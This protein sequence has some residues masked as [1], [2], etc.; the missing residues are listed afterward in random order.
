MR[1][2]QRE[3]VYNLWYIIC[4]SYGGN[5]GENENFG[6]WRH[7]ELGLG[8]YENDQ[9]LTMCLLW[10]G[11]TGTTSSN[12]SEYCLTRDSTGQLKSTFLPSPTKWFHGGYHLATHVCTC[13]DSKDLRCLGL[14]LSS[15]SPWTN[16]LHHDRIKQGI[17]HEIIIQVKGIFEPYHKVWLCPNMGRKTPQPFLIGHFW[18]LTW[19]WTTFHRA[20][21]KPQ[22]PPREPQ[23]ALAPRPHRGKPNLHPSCRTGIIMGRPFGP[24]A[25][26]QWLV[27]GTARGSRIR[28]LLVQFDECKNFGENCQEIHLHQLP[29]TYQLQRTSHLQ[30]TTKT[31]KNGIMLDGRFLPM[32]IWGNTKNYQSYLRTYL[33]TLGSSFLSVNGFW[34]Q[35]P[36][37]DLSYI[38]TFAYRTLDLDRISLMCKSQ[39]SRWKSRSV[40]TCASVMV[41]RSISQIKPGTSHWCWN[42]KLASMLKSPFQSCHITFFIGQITFLCWKITVCLLALITIMFVP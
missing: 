37:Q 14:P 42:L 9:I 22:G 28:V 25:K 3:L 13:P 26:N 33:V 23:L 36:S 4:N 30:A 27:F 41:I 1:G 38:D 18:C 17:H 34:K 21:S 40:R 15:R 2:I 32:I 7:T 16:D 31:L 19:W 39:G 5:I 35:Y 10:M 24:F 29:N 11:P 12:I 6:A 20:F 8:W